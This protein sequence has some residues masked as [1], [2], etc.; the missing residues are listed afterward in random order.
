MTK[1]TRPAAQRPEPQ[2]ATRREAAPPVAEAQPDSRPLTELKHYMRPSSSAQQKELVVEKV[3]AGSSTARFLER[4]EERR[5]KREC[6][7]VVDMRGKTPYECRSYAYRNRVFWLDDPSYRTFLRGL[8]EHNGVFTVETYEEILSA[9]HT[10]DAP[11]GL[12]SAAEQ[13]PATETS[14]A[15]PATLLQDP[16][17]RPP[18]PPAAPIPLGYYRNRRRPRVQH[19]TDVLAR[20]ETGAFPL[21][22]RDLS[23]DGLCLVSPHA[24]PVEPG[25]RLLLS[26]VRFNEEHDAGLVDIPYEVVAQEE[27][28]SGH[29]L[30]LRLREGTEPPAFLERFIESNLRGSRRKRKFELGDERLTAESLLAELY[31]TRSSAAVPLFLV[32]DGEGRARLDLVCANP[33]NRETLAVFGNAHGDLE[34]GALAHPELVQA[35]SNH[36]SEGGQ[37]DPCLMVFRHAPREPVRI[38]ADFQFDGPETWLRVRRQLATAHALRV[39]KVMLRPTARPDSRKILCALGRLSD[40]SAD[41]AEELVATMDRSLAA[42]VLV[43]ITAQTAP[44]AGPGENGDPLEL[45]PAF[46]SDPAVRAP[47]VLPFGYVEQ[48]REHRYRIRLGVHVELAGQARE[49]TTED[50]SVRGLSLVVPDRLQVRRGDLVQLS[51]PEL[52]KRAR[53]RVRLLDIAHEVMGVEYGAGST[54]LRLKRS[55]TRGEEACAAFFKELIE[56]NR[57]RLEV[58]LSEARTAAQARAY[59]CLAAENSASLPLYIFRREGLEARVGLPRNR[60]SFLEFFEV[61]PGRYDF[62]PLS[63]PGRLAQLIAGLREGE[64]TSTT[65][66]MCKVWR[67]GDTGFDICSAMDSDFADAGERQAFLDEALNHDC[68]F[69]RVVAAPVREIDRSEENEALDSFL[70]ISPHHAN[71][72]RTE[73][74][75]LV[76]VADVVDVTRQV[77]DSLG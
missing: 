33:N 21:K 56:R 19:A 8:K 47:L 9:G 15:G 60:G 58:D 52:N 69:V 26:F 77:M 51:F 72:L 70:A 1:G 16:R 50:I 75:G 23:A 17:F 30:R 27:G 20:A 61:G 71:R 63:V 66:Y 59:A 38:L 12:E 25:Q 44:E 73:Y 43:D 45:P 29:H 35:L 62:S 7:L 32:R 53:G 64:S 13:A 76:A 49:A 6:M 18:A 40:R 4:M 10:R 3:Q 11:T 42:G 67:P 31:Y 68:C 37:R 28:R 55:D 39:F 24:L 5:R 74:Q 46:E 41:A 57:D 48:R 34:L 22:T 2:F 14:A 54:T 65:L 36:I